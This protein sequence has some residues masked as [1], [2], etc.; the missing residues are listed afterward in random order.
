MQFL[1]AFLFSF[2]GLCRFCGAVALLCVKWNEINTF[3]CTFF[4]SFVQSHIEIMFFFIV[5]LIEFCN[6]LVS[7]LDLVECNSTNKLPPKLSTW[8]FAFQF[9]ERACYGICHIRMAK[10]NQLVNIAH[11]YFGVVVSLIIATERVF[12]W[13]K[14]RGSKIICEPKEL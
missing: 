13:Q 1:C 12:Q 7:T 14:G 11:R 3:V 6:R 5:D 2:L 4:A 10:W 8:V 9:N